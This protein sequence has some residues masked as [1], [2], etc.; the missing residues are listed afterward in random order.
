MGLL[1][2]I[3]GR[4]PPIDERLTADEARQARVPGRVEIQ[5]VEEQQGTRQRMEA[6]MDAQR[7]RRAQDAP[8]K[9]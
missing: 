8:P 7:E 9:A 4:K 1:G 3:F 5:S 2:R 6:E